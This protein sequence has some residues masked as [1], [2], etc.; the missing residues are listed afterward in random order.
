MSRLFAHAARFCI[1]AIVLVA[2]TPPPSIRGVPSPTAVAEFLR[3]VTRDPAIP[4]SLTRVGQSAPP[5]LSSICLST[6]TEA[7]FD[8]LEDM[9]TR[10]GE[11]RKFANRLRGSFRVDTV[12]FR[13]G[14]SLY[15]SA[16]SVVNVQQADTCVSGVERERLWVAVSPAIS[17]PYSDRAGRIG[18]FADVRVESA[19]GLVIDRYLY[20]VGL[21]EKPIPAK[22]AVAQVVRVGTGLDNIT[23]ERTQ[24]FP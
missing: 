16:G 24:L 6:R 21:I 7:L 15:D 10:K 23:A 17:N 14:S 9:S 2:C 4:R 11:A 8:P 12:D 3:V 22:T 19:R 13:W 5:S 18:F 1:L 20:W